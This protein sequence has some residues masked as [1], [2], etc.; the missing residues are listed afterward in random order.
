MIH[1]FLSASCPW[2]LLALFVAV[3]CSLM[4]RRHR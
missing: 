4:F 2:I 1:E 3:S